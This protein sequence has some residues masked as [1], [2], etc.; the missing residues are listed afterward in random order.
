MGVAE[1][2]LGEYIDLPFGKMKAMCIK[3]YDKALKRSYG[4]YMTIPPT[5]KQV[6]YPSEKELTRISFEMDEELEKYLNMIQ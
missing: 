2:D 4:E 6:P 1:N 5:E 3:N